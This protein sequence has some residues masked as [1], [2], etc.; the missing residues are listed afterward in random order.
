MPY[1]VDN[2]FFQAGAERAAAGREELRREL[3]LS[4]G[5]PVILSVSKIE[6]RKRPADLL[7]AYIKL[8]KTGTVA[9]PPYLLFVGDGEQRRPPG[10]GRQGNAS[11]RA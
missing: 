2:P 4:P 1:T 3:G 5:R 9:G 7:A 11:R 8:I 10:R 6:P